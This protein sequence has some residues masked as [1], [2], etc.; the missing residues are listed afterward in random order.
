MGKV[1]GFDALQQTRTPFL[2]F[3]LLKHTKPKTR[4]GFLHPQPFLVF[5][6]LKHTKPKTRKGLLHPRPFL[7]FML[8]KQAEP[9]ARKGFHT[10]QAALNMTLSLG[11]ASLLGSSHCSGSPDN[12]MILGKDSC[13]R[14]RLL[15]SRETLV[16]GEDSCHA[17]VV[18][19]GETLVVGGE[20][21]RRPA[22]KIL[23]STSSQTLGVFTLLRIPL[24]TS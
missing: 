16:V 12:F 14:G 24:T 1:P 18:G 19:G 10:A 22:Q 6:L 20:S 5:M 13:R 7:V 17:L 2:V 15:S 9:Q 11:P 23:S 21:C 3:M 4:K 8:L